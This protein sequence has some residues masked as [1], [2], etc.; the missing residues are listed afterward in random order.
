MR[1]DD[2]SLGAKFWLI[3]MGATIGL[4]IAVIVLFIFIDLVWYAWG[5]I[6]A[7][8]FVFFVAGLIGW[9]FDRRAQKRYEDLPADA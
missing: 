2:E 4:A 5:A 8:L 7:L 9:I 3:V 1:D 6:G